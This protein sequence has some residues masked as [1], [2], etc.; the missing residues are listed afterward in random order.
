M[1]TE[2]RPARTVQSEAHTLRRR[3]TMHRE[4]LRRD[5]EKLAYRINLV[6]TL[7]ARLAEL[8]QDEQ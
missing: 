4:G 3:L 5:E 8:E 2:S 7:E 1:T 6:K